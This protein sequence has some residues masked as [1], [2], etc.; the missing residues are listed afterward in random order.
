MMD[1]N[2]IRIPIPIVE[3][4]D[5]RDLCAILTSLGLEVR[6]V[7]IRATKSGT[8]KRYVEYRDTGCDKPR[9]E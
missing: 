8:S 9:T 3:E 4:R 1:V 6:V 7:R 5:R 2:W